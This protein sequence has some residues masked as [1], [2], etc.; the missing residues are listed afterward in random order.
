MPDW[1]SCQFENVF[2]RENLT[3]EEKRRN[4]MTQV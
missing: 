3:F 2:S 1:E 4:Y